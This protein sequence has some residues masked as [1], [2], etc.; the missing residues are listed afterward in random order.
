MQGA[1][2]TTHKC[3][4]EG[5]GYISCR[6]PKE[7]RML[8]CVREGFVPKGAFHVWIKRNKCMTKC[9]Y[10]YGSKLPLLHLFWPCVAVNSCVS[11]ALN[12]SASLHFI[13]F[14]SQF[15]II[16]LPWRDEHTHHSFQLIMHR[17]LIEK[18]DNKIKK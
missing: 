6:M 1:Q 8:L 4:R 15:F 18:Y 16:S 17:H 2:V 10:V 12:H 14:F 3:Q 5:S 13:F 9:L 11:E 7:C